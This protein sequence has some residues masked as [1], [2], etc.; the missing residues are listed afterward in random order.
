M[1]PVI[2]RGRGRG[3]PISSA[4]TP[5]VGSNRMA[6]TLVRV[7]NNSVGTLEP[8]DL[9]SGT[10]TK[11]RLDQYFIAQ[12]VTDDTKKKAIFLCS[13]GS[14]VCDLVWDL[15]SPTDPTEDGVSYA[16]LCTRLKTHLVPTKVEIAEQFKF[17]QRKQKEEESIKDFE[18]ALRNLAKYCAFETILDSALRDAF[19]I[20]LVD[21]NIQTKLLTEENL[22]LAAAITKAQGMEATSS[23][24]KQFRNKGP[25]PELD[26]TALNFIGGK[27]VCWGCGF[28]GHRQD[29]CVYRNL[30]C[31]GCKEKGHKATVCPKKKNQR[32]T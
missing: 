32:G 7:T 26:S 4:L 19:V 2:G 6:T 21:N 28:S 22:T 9:Q 10:S 12:D 15:F 17:Y 18:G 5:R 16:Q 23:Q 25:I 20:G 13:V 1:Q 24:S 14:E 27:G 29:D 11:A 30:D 8:F 31:F 3:Q